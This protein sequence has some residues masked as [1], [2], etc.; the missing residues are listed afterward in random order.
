M[1][2]Q[3]EID[4]SFSEYYGNSVVMILFSIMHYKTLLK[5]CIYFSGF[6]QNMQV[7]PMKEQSVAYDNMLLFFVYITI[8]NLMCILKCY[9]TSGALKT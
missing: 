6:A 9:V 2:F 5:M 1:H 3:I 8:Y 4:L 7:F